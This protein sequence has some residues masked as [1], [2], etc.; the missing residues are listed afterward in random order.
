ME[1][2]ELCASSMMV[3]RKSPSSGTH[4]HDR[5]KRK[6]RKGKK[7]RKERKGKEKIK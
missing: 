4:I 6:R 7:E 3:C 2:A 1:Y 5:R